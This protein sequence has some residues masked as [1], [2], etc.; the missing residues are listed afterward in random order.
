M[1]L[2]SSS[3]YYQPLA[4]LEAQEQSDA[5]LR[6]HIERLQQDFPGYGYRRLGQQLRREGVVV[7]DKKIRRIQRKYQ[8]FPIRWRSF[9][10]ATTDSNHN[11]KVYPNLL[12]DKIL[13][14]LNQAWVADITYIRILKGFVFLAALLDRFS[15]KVI[16]WAISKR[17]DA[18]LCVAALRIALEQR[19]HPAAFTTPIAACSTPVPSI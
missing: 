18:E 5:L 11:H 9:K 6:D 3:Y 13:T 1:K 19:P 17:I 16:G 14:G 8:L 4:D 15:R 10:I 12:A 2:A 7:N